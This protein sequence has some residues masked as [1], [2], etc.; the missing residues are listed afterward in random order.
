MREADLVGAWSL[1]DFRIAFDDGRPPIEPY[2][3]G[4]TGWLLYAESGRMSAVIS[5]AHREPL[6]VPRLEAAHRAPDAEKAAAFDGYLSYAGTWRLTG[7]EV[8]HDVTEALVPNIV[9]HAHRRRAA[10]DDDV[11]TLSYRGGAKTYTLR[12]RRS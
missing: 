5:R 9:G 11:L 4:A 7:E 8:V 1:I 10:L 3:A 2:G 6:S 12:W